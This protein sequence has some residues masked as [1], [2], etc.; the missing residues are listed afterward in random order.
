MINGIKIE[1]FTGYFK[2]FRWKF[3]YYTIVNSI[4]Y[5]SV[6]EDFELKD[7]KGC[8]F[9]GI[10]KIVENETTNNKLTLYTGS[11]NWY[12]RGN[13][14]E[15]FNLKNAIQKGI[16]EAK[17]LNLNE[18]KIIISDNTDEEEMSFMDSNTND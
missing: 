2:I 14:L 15:I 8:A 16:S 17:I 4:F 18:T 6:N 11:K 3:R 9:L 5:Y 10:C 13:E 12:F 7:A 1:K